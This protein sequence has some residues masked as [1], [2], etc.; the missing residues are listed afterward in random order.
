MSKPEFIDVHG[1]LNEPKY[2]D[3]IQWAED[4]T[5]AIGA[6]NSITLLH[7]GNMPGPRCFVS[8]DGRCDPAALNAA[9][10]PE[11]LGSL[12]SYEFTSMRALTMKATYANV[13]TLA[14]AR[15][16]AWSPAGCGDTGSCLLAVVTVDH[17]VRHTLGILCYSV[18][19]PLFPL[20]PTMGIYYAN[21]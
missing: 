4:G 17:A 19:P 6:G 5:L 8:L 16:M 7:P 11:N 3:C 21:K 9:G 13:Q 10:Q 2:P 20:V 14:E 18:S 1:V 12:A 15:S